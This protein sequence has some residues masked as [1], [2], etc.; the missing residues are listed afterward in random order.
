MYNLEQNGLFR[1]IYALFW[2]FA[3]FPIDDHLGLPLSQEAVY[4]LHCANL[5]RLQ[6]VSLRKYKSKLTLLALSNFGAI[7]KPTDLA[8]HFSQLTDSE[9]A[10]LASGLGLRTEY[11]P[12]I[13]TSA[14]RELVLEVLYSAH[15]R[16]KSYQDSLRSLGSVPTEVKPD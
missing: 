2:H 6:R 4:E 1:D 10:G 3:K 15:E 11:P 8:T 9:L 5:A 12:T 14:N 16:R 13:G 7:G